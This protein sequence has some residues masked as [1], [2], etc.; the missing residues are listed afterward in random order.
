MAEWI[1]AAVS[2]GLECG[3]LHFAP[4]KMHDDLGVDESGMDVPFDGGT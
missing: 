3:D 4:G 2:S 1:E